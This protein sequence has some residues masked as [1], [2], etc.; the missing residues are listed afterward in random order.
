MERTHRISGLRMGIAVGAAIAL[1]GI[2]VGVA[3]ASIPAG[4]GTINACYA[5]SSGA[6]RVIDY[7]SHHCASGERLLRWNQTS[8]PGA[9]PLLALAGTGCAGIGGS[10]TLYLGV[11][12]G[13]G[14]VT[15]TCR[16]LL[17]LQSAIKLTEIDLSAGPPGQALTQQCLNATT[18]SLLVPYG[19]TPA[20]ANFIAPVDIAFTCPGDTVASTGSPDIARTHF[21]GICQGITLNVDR[22]VVVGAR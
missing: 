12:P 19:S 16:T 17:T 1:L 6:L 11:T 5:T 7:P 3:V 4:G 13:T 21:S 9:V 20:Q 22:T 2:A 8:A 14:T 18:C 10:G 15:F